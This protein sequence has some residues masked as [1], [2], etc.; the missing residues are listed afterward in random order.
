MKSINLYTGISESF[1][2]LSTWKIKKKIVF[3]KL[4]FLLFAAT[5]T[6]NIYQS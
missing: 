1:K 2:K 5:L 6:P 3:G 4:N